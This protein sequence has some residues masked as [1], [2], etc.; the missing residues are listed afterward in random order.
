MK[1]P[2]FE[3]P[4][5]NAMDYYWFDQGFTPEELNKIYTQVATLPFEVASTQ[6]G[7]SDDRKSKIKWIPQTEEWMWLY[8]KLI[9]L[10]A[11]AN[12]EMWNFDL[13]TA[14][15]EIQYTEYYETDQG[16]YDWHIDLG[17]ERL[18]STRK[19]GFT[20]F[21]NDDYEGGEFYIDA[22]EQYGETS[23]RLVNTLKPKGSVTVFPSHIWHKVD[24]VIKG[25]RYSI[26]VWVKGDPFK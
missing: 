16:K 22:E 1:V 19:L 15:E 12:K 6:G 25:T 26:V 20:L 21:L 8:E 14:P 4:Q 3:S 5:N 11:H 7:M 24:P 13:H 9:E 2:T 17:P 18:A 10:A 23:P